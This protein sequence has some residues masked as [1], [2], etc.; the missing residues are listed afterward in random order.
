MENDVKFF[1]AFYLDCK[2]H[3]VDDMVAIE[4]PTG[5]TLFVNGK[6][7]GS[8]FAQKT[9]TADGFEDLSFDSSQDLASMIRA[10][11][12]WSLSF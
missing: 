5:A 7:D 8:S 4:L 10:T 9:E 3:V 12:E 1:D 11:R 6:V 2:M